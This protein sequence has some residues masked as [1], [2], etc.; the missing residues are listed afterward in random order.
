MSHPVRRLSPPPDVALERIGQT[1]LGL[2]ASR[3]IKTPGSNQHGSIPL[4]PRRSCKTQSTVRKF[5]TDDNRKVYLMHTC[6]VVCIMSVQCLQCLQKCAQSLHY[7]SCAYL[8]M[9]TEKCL[10]CTLLYYSALCLLKVCTS[11]HLVCIKSAFSPTTSCSQNN[12]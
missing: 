1:T 3:S 10:N 6:M 11:L 7:P 2:P 12:S 9:T 8:H 4:T 5:S